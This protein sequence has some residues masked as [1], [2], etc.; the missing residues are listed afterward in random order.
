MT[1]ICDFCSDRGPTW[2]FACETYILAEYKTRS[3]GSWLACEAC[4]LMIHT[5]NWHGLAVR[6]CE[7][8]P[9]GRVLVELIGK[10]NAVKRTK[11]MHRS[12]RDHA[13]GES[14]PLK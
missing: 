3:I 13:N 10:D 6:S 1:A 7:K 12:F 8:N 5:H 11:E 14:H 2:S 9:S 4:A